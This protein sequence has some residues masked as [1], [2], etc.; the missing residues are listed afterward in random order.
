MKKLFRKRSSRYP[1]NE[2]IK[3]K[4]HSNKKNLT[5]KLGK[6]I[7]WFGFNLAM[8]SKSFAYDKS[9]DNVS[10]KVDELPKKDKLQENV[11]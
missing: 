2:R 10:L 6:N 4:W 5:S 8:K 1:N 9:S 3:S 11:K 7:M